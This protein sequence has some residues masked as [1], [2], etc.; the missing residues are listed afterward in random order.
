MR[1]TLE[2]VQR[3]QRRD[4]E[5]EREEKV[6]SGRQGCPAQGRVIKE[7]KESDISGV[8]FYLLK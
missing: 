5:K 3:F 1:A 4:G 8:L 7:L 2:F 6:K